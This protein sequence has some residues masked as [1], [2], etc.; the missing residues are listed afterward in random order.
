MNAGTSI[1]LIVLVLIGSFAGLG[2][3]IN[4]NVAAAQDRDAALTH[5]GELEAQACSSGWRRARQKL[6]ASGKP[7]KQPILRRAGCRLR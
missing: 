4:Q 6:P 2:Y 7:K 5:S 1:F 3:L